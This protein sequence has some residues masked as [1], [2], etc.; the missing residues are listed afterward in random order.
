MSAKREYIYFKWNTGKELG[1]IDLNKKTN[2][3][4]E[5]AYKHFMVNFKIDGDSL[6][7]LELDEEV[8][9]YYLTI[10]QIKPKL[11]FEKQ[12]S[13][14]LV[15][16]DS[17]DKP[18]ESKE[19]LSFTNFAI[20]HNC[21]ER[22]SKGII[23][24]TAFIFNKKNS[25]MEKR[26]SLVSAQFLDAFI[27]TSQTGIGAIS[28]SSLVECSYYPI[29]GGKITGLHIFQKKEKQQKVVSYIFCMTEHASGLEVMRVEEQNVSKKVQMTKVYK[30]P[31]ER[32]NIQKPIKF[33]SFDN[34]LNF[35][36]KNKL[37]SFEVIC[38]PKKKRGKKKADGS[39]TDDRQTE[40]SP[41]NLIMA[42]EMLKLG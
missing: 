11:E 35:F 34:T 5:Y 13:I 37:F 1:V 7:T 24:F 12:H 23:V 14:V 10:C 6:F 21:M 15:D 8:H 17:P 39:K 26:Y 36:N 32:T 9:Q 38:K 2:P 41:E 22:D 42:A 20:S 4:G 25:A 27:Q 40:D 29:F 16:G 18:Q 31:E 33:C 30:L 3:V 19:L 28:F